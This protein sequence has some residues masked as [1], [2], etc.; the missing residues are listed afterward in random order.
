MGERPA[1]TAQ[2]QA[3]MQQ[4]RTLV[5]QNRAQT[6]AR[7]LAALTPAHRTAV[8]SIVGQL[9]L[10]TTPNPKAAIQSLDAILAPAEKTSIL[11]ISA[12]DKAN[13]R[14]IMQQQRSI[15]ESSMTADQK[16]AMAQREAQRQTFM[17]AHPRPAHVPDAGAILLRTLGD[18]GGPGGPG[19]RWGMG[20]R[21]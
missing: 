11:N 12:A 1:L 2:Q 7:L 15:M 10:S 20:M 4:V 8:A 17:Q 21:G 19:G 13:M 16:A 18:V 14:T 5:E 3:A 6:R 9:V